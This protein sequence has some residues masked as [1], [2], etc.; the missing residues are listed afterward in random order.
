MN[1]KFFLALIAIAGAAHLPA[2]DTASPRPFG[3]NSLNQLW[4]RGKA[5]GSGPVRLKSFPLRAENLQSVIPMGMMVHGHVIPSDHLSLQPKDRNAA[6]DRYEVVAPADGFIVDIHRPP[7]GNPD[8]G[9]RGYAGDFRIV[10]EH[11]AT[12][13]S[14]LGLVDRLDESILK[15]MGGAPAA[16]APV[17]VRV[18]VKAGQI[19]GRMGGSHGLDY[20]L[21]NT[22]A[23]LKGF[24]NPA[25]FLHR[26]QWK[27]HVV[28]PFTFL[29]GPEKPRL[30][31]LNPRQAEP[32]GGRIDFDVDGALA[33]NW[34]REGSGGYAGLNRRMDYWVGH[35]AFAYH[36]IDPTKLVV[37][38]GDYEG[39]PR[40][41]W[42]KGNTPDPA[43]VTERDGV[44][45]YEL[46]W[47]RL[48]NSGQPFEGLPTA[49]QGVVLAQILADRRLKFE[50]FPGRSSAEVKGFTEA[51]RLYTR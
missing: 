45:R 44:M 21:I 6:S 4:S 49:V 41:F 32:R 43:K 17:G 28:D 16:G 18:P 1:A 37:S 34:Y 23:T 26:D 40:Q 51:A 9:V 22:E 30:L 50:A 48:N 25:Q 10:I 13:Y 11:S 33:G 47:G 35:V 12:C 31:A 46:V 7:S 19:I 15:A 20:T 29:D 14:W 39:K 24:I 36:H 42:V 38:I 3:A 2:Q 27:P 8:P 5:T